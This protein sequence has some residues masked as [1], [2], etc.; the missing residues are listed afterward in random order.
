MPRL[1]RL[2]QFLHR[3][4][5]YWYLR[6]R[7]P[8][9]I[10]ALIQRTEFQ[11]SLA[12]TDRQVACH[13]ARVLYPHIYSIRRLAKLMATLTREDV[14]RALRRALTR[15][16]VDL[17]RTREPWFRHDPVQELMRQNSMVSSQ[18][19]GNPQFINADGVARMRA[20]SNI[21]SVQQAIRQRNYRSVEP[22]AREVLAEVGVDAPE[23][24]PEFSQLCEELLKIGALWWQVDL[25]RT[26]GEFDSE[27]RYLAPYIRRGLLN[28]PAVNQVRPN[29]LA[30]SA[31]SPLLS[32]AWTEYVQ[33]K[34][35][36]RGRARW[37][38]KTASLSPIS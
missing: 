15:L 32:K 22:R 28:D 19:A 4:R 10:Q 12:T 18:L 11:L 17:E 6:F 24:S 14:E 36:V 34:T 9:A 1:R 33:E 29:N 31:P 25:D 8:A 2:T 26:N 13:R 3:R 37:R 27:A 38:K 16:V 5:A 20:S 7:F 30:V 35:A 23:P 21:A